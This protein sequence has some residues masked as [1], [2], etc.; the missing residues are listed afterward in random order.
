MQ[1]LR[2][3]SFS[4]TVSSCASLTPHCFPILQLLQAILLPENT[5][6]HRTGSP[7][8]PL[9]AT[10]CKYC[11]E[12]G[13]P[14]ISPDRTPALQVSTTEY[15]VLVTSL[16]NHPQLPSLV[17]NSVNLEDTQINN[18]KSSSVLSSSHTLG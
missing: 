10:G 9:Q 2:E 4:Y 17:N 5:R 16:G 18:L 6:E 12:A 14:F 13:V 7:G 15:S 11:L 1:Q 8:D 3:L